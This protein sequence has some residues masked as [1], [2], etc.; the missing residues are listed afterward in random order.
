[1]APDPGEDARDAPLPRRR[2]IA[3]WAL[4]GIPSRVL[5]PVLLVE[6]VAVL[7]VVVGLAGRAPLPTDRLWVAITLGLGG[8]AHT[9]VA[10]GIERVRRRVTDGNH[11]DMNSVWTFAAALVLP[12]AYAALLAIVVHLHIWWRAWRPRVPL[13]K[14]LFST[15]TVVLACFA[16]SA[17]LEYA[18]GTGLG[19][20]LL[21][22]LAYTTVN[23]CLVAGAI[24][25][26]TP[27][28]SLAKVF[29]SWEEN[30]L[31]IATLCLGALTAIAV[32]INLSLI[33]LILPPMVVLHRAWL[34]S[35]LQTAATT[36][37][38]TG[39]LNAAAWH[40]KAE[41]ALRRSEGIESPRGVLVLDLDHFKAVNDSHGHIA[42]D[43]VLLAVAK[44]LA[45]EVRD[46]DLVG[47]FGG[48]EFVVLLSGLP[49]D[50]VAELRAV[51]ERMRGRVA[52]L[53]VQIPT[54]DGPLTVAGLTIS[55]GGAVHPGPGQDLRSLLQIAD[56]ALYSA[57]R[58]G[59][60]KVRM[61]LSMPSPRPAAARQAGGE[62]PPAQP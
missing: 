19:P 25:M 29:A 34:V 4:W 58:D 33:V 46:R 24:A 36:D 42:G 62:Q 40:S 35:H 20:I 27:N 9:E 5:A 39:L 11:V 12:G 14:Q 23:S 16:A 54:P 59:R 3:Q 47:R 49:G 1:M 48:E 28:A 52:G 18:G 37:V 56:T 6:A 57:K 15:A 50:G 43:Q 8:M 10:V 21:A 60:N 32:T 31:E 38:K 17:S 55:I 13:Y 45:D 30:M 26:S 53:Q 41:Q 51:A 2:R 61:G 22:L 44:A 7:L